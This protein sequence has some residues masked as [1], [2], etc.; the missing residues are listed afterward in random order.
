MTICSDCQ[1]PIKNPIRNMV[2]KDLQKYNPNLKQVC[3]H[4]AKIAEYKSFLVIKRKV[5]PVEVEVD[6]II[7]TNY[8]D[9]R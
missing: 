2:M 8:S 7:V 1:Q 4:C 9:Y 3:E 5:K 6:G